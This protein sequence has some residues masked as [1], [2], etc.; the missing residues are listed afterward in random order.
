MNANSKAHTHMHNI[1]PTPIITSDTAKVTVLVKMSLTR[2][3]S[4]QKWANCW[5]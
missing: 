2:H 3:P 4:H 5:C 1:S